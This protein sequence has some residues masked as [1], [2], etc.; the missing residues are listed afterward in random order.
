VE[1]DDFT[2][3]ATFDETGMAGCGTCGVTVLTVLVDNGWGERNFEDRGG[4][5]GDLWETLFGKLAGE[6]PAGTR[7]D[8]TESGTSGIR[9][10]AGREPGEIWAGGNLS[11]P[12]CGLAGAVRK[13]G[14]GTAE[15]GCGET[16][17]IGGGTGGAVATPF[18]A[19]P[20]D[21][22]ART[23]GAEPFAQL[24]SRL[25][26]ARSELGGTDWPAK[27]SARIGSFFGNHAL[28]N[29]STGFLGSRRCRGMLSQLGRESSA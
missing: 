4:T 3:R 2:S 6:L 23:T 1:G 21:V 15:E 9:S 16:T 26:F 10:N 19:C 14:G 29:E 18:S 28:G 24:R 20:A 5:A 22:G 7:C 13:L 8:C 12:A 11:T 27:G 17:G 25:G